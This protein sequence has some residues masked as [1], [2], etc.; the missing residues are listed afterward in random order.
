MYFFHSDGGALL[1][2]STQ[3][4]LLHKRYEITP[5]SYYEPPL[6][7]GNSMIYLFGFAGNSIVMYPLI[8]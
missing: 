4:G 6:I 5:L 7:V 8:I 1:A 2:L 3:D